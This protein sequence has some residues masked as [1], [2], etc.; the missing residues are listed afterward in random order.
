[1]RPDQDLIVNVEGTFDPG[2]GQISWVF[3]SLD[4]DTMGIPA[5]PL[6]GFLP[7]ITEVGQEIGWVS[8]SVDAK[9]GLES[10]TRITNQAFVKFDVGEFN[11][12]PKEGPFVNTIDIT[13]PAAAQNKS[14]LEKLTTLTGQTVGY[15]ATLHA[16]PL[17]VSVI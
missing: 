12:A 17:Q 7:P 1:M 9:T 2:T 13:G 8:F 4:P 6:A 16:D 15:P 11:P 5:D 10:G 3:R 14:L